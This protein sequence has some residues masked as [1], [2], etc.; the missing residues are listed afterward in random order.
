VTFEDLGGNRTKM[1]FR[2]V[3]DTAEDRQRTVEVYKA[4]VGLQQTIGRLE[5][6]LAKQ[7]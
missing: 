5:E 1:T 4:D 3:F 2:M 6:Y 7:R